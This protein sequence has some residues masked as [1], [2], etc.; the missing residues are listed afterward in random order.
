MS[1]NLLQ[2][3]HAQLNEF[4]PGGILSSSICQ[5]KIFET[6]DVAMENHRNLAGELSLLSDR[7]RRIVH[8]TLGVDS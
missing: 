4:Y 5:T 2:V 3:L 8:G 1:R 7:T 6:V